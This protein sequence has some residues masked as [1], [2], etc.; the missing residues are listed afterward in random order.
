MHGEI[1]PREDR[2]ENRH[3]CTLSGGSDR[4]RA[5][6]LGDID[7]TSE[8]RLNRSGARHV[9]QFSVETVFV[10]QFEVM[11]NPEWRV[12]IREG[13]VCQMDSFLRRGR[14][15]N[16]TEKKRSDQNDRNECYGMNF[17]R[18]RKQRHTAKFILS[19]SC[20][21]LMSSGKIETGA[22]EG[23]SRNP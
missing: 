4:G 6:D 5:A 11:S 9:N 23:R 16:A 3:V 14:R 13:A 22:D 2:A 20:F 8:H 1:E 19:S 21:A 15:E 12:G 10:E 18:H 17:C 7:R